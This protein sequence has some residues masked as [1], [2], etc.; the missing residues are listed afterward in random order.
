M[1]ASLWMLN[2][3]TR[4]FGLGRI[5]EVFATFCVFFASR[6]F[7]LSTMFPPPF[8]RVFVQPP[9]SPSAHRATNRSP[10]RPRSASSMLGIMQSYSCEFTRQN[11]IILRSYPAMPTNDIN[12]IANR[13]ALTQ[14][15]IWQAAT[16]KSW[17]VLAW[18]MIPFHWY[19]VLWLGNS[20]SITPFTDLGM[21]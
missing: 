20:P 18:F 5:A 1:F 4:T 3:T 17:S 9:L 19:N 2:P 15:S 14:F 12:E 13:L 8:F 10:S 7:D 21:R 6:F 11:E 16:K